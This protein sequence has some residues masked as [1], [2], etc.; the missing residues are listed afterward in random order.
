MHLQVELLLYEII[1]KKPKIF[2]QLVLDVE[3]VL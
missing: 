3:N 1:G 2:L